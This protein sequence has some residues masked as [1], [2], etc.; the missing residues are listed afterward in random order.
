MKLECDRLSPNP[1][2]WHEA[3]AGHIWIVDSFTWEHRFLSFR[4]TDKHKNKPLQRPKA[5]RPAWQSLER[6]WLGVPPNPLLF[7]GAISL[8]NQLARPRA[9]LI[10]IWT[11][12]PEL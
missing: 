9:P 3:E 5:G 7:L 11:Q 8:L 10:L 12:K 4:E 6:K 2:S 1:I